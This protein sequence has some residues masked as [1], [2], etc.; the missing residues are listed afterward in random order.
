MR[1]LRAS[2]RNYRVHRELTVEFAN[3]VTAIAA[4]NEYG[5]ST[6]L[7]AIHRALFLKHRTGGEIRKAMSSRHGGH[8]EVELHFEVGAVRFRLRKLFATQSGQCELTDETSGRS[9]KSDEAEAQLARLVGREPIGSN[10][11]ELDAA[12]D[13]LWIWQ[14]KAD[15]DPLQT[16]GAAEL[17]R[18]LDGSLGEAEAQALVAGDARVLDLLRQRVDATWTKARDTAKK[19]SE[20]GRALAQCEEAKQELEIVRARRAERAERIEQLAAARSALANARAE[21]V[22]L[23]PELAACEA[24]HAALEALRQQDEVAQKDRERRTAELAACDELANQMAAAR[25]RLAPAEERLRKSVADVEQAQ[26]DLDATRRSRDAA[27]DRARACER[28]GAKARDAATAAR[29]VRERADRQ[30]Q[31]TRLQEE[32]DRFA[33]AQGALATA[34]QALATA[35]PIRDADVELL[36]QREKSLQSAMDR[37]DGAAVR[38][39]R[40]SGTS[41]LLLD[42][43]PIATGESV[44]VREVAELRTADGSVVEVRPGGG[45]LETLRKEKAKCEAALRDELLRLGVADVAAARAAATANAALA[46][47]VEQERG[48]IRLLRDP[49]IE[50]QK[51]PG[52]LARLDQEI[53]EL[54]AR[55]V[56][57]EAGADPEALQR[58][59]MAAEQQRETLLGLVAECRATV[60]DAEAV[61][62]TAASKQLEAERAAQQARTEL[63]QLAKRVG[64]E[65]AFEARRRA[66]REQVVADATSGREAAKRIEGLKAAASRLADHRKH[67]ALLDKE[68]ATQDARVGVLADQVQGEHREDLD[69]A[70]DELEARLALRERLA[71]AARARAEGEKVL[72]ELMVSLQQE[73]RSRREAPFVAACDRYLAIAHGPGIRASL[74]GEDSRELGRIDRTSVGLGAFAFRELSQ[75]GRELTALAVRLA[76]AEVLAKEQPDGALPLVLDDAVTN[77]D[78]ERLRMVGFLLAEAARNG[79]QVVFAT[80]DVERAPGLRADRLVPLP[81]PA[82]GSSTPVPVEGD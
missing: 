47:A 10:K 41:P 42:G 52:V 30:E 3:G 25:L 61:Q 9:W 51:L 31:L 4:P 48:R 8:P 66:L 21:K 75:G 43:K 77:V 44:R 11:R 32:R 71:A 36:L 20:L 23:G 62:A 16:T 67:E 26:R 19:D 57:A 79:V 12:W 17:Q 45:E 13:H 24:E 22:R 27:D 37:L 59:A 55:G 78:P 15:G 6:L 80:C 69:A 60:R 72:L 81:R 1:L 35:L 2:I 56:V 46:F 53:A 7:E 49:G 5:K 40:T 68:L 39:A 18:A 38:L 76:M 70:I 54:G 82:W 50:L 14:G 29:L 64:D 73:Q 34:E 74:D 28:D 33:T 58:A 65:V 63:D